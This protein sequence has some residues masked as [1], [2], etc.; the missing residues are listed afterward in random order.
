MSAEA[1]TA[2]KGDE[3]KGKAQEAWGNLTDDDEEV[4][5]GRANQAKGK[6]KQALDNVESAVED[7]TPGRH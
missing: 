2:G 7:V 3:I 1:G 6:G 5:K 4:A